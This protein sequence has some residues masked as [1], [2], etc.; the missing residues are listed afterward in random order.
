MS[1]SSTDEFIKTEFEKSIADLQ[2]NF[3]KTPVAIIWPGGSFGAKPVQIAREYG[4]RLGFT[5]NPRGPVLYN[6]VRS[7]A[8]RVGEDSEARRHTHTEDA[9]STDS[10]SDG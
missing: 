6:G 3:N 9:H 10:C 7:E 1:D 2:T 5:V 4:Y 8:R